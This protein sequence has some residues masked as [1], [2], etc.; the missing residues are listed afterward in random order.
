MGIIRRTALS[1]GLLAVVAAAVVI[2]T[3]V[4]RHHTAA[5]Q[6][7]T[8]A[9]TTA[10]KVV[11]ADLRTTQ[12]FYGTL[13]YGTPVAIGAATSRG[14]YTWLPAAG[15]VIHQ[16][17]ALYEVDGHGVP[18]LS[19][20]RPMW[21]ALSVN[22]T[23]GP[24]IAELNTDLVALGYATGIAGNPSYDWRTRAA[25]ED[26]Q[27][28]RGVTV[29]GTVAVGQVVFAHAPL[30]VDAVTATLGA[31]AQAG[32]PLLTATPT[33]QAVT[34]PVPV[35]QIYLIRRGASV[36]VTLP[37]AVTTAPGIV[38][39]IAR[40]ATQPPDNGTSNSRPQP[41]TVA[42]TI[43]LTRP[44]VA[45]RYT[46]APVSVEVTT[47]EVRHVLA[48]PIAALLARPDGTFAVTV[49]NGA[50]QHDV[51][52]TTGLYSD[53]LVQVSGTGLAA[54]SSVLVPSS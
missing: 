41:A 34:L 12:Q 31:P 16:G 17:Q 36:T 46:S 3:I 18:L 39:E 43:R 23:D 38:S 28:A 49:V 35:D 25:V 29:T 10:A 2:T 14:L 21:R 8:T 42:V 4:A 26:W 44:A 20:S 40:A 32:A 48:V 24:D 19:G 47:A 13:G 27:S 6:P 54:G 33:T 9:Q 15:A 22:A 52:V 45:A 5:A 1:T 51:A 37:D 30:R 7:A 11:R 53:A 50:E